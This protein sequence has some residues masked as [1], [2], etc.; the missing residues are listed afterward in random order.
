VQHRVHRGGSVGGDGILAVPP[1]DLA[2]QRVGQPAQRHPDQPAARLIRNAFSGPL[3]RRG[4]ERL[5]HGLLGRREV[6][7]AADHR[8]EHL[9]RQVAQQVLYGHPTSLG[10][11][12][13]ICRTS[14]HRCS[15]SLP[16]GPL[17]G[18]PGAV[19]ASAAI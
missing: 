19:E 4:D 10:G 12:L 5:L 16:S 3:L 6:L 2:A 7:R 9:G 17:T 11:P 1:G 18:A 13:M 8:A 15:I 14:I